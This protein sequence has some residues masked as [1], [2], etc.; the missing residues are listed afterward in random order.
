MIEKKTKTARARKIQAALAAI[1]I[2]AASAACAAAAFSGCAK[3]SRK[4]EPSCATRYPILLV[5][6]LSWRDDGIVSYWGTVPEALTERGARVYLSRHDA[7]GSI[8]DNAAKIDERVEAILAETGAGKVNVIAHSKGG[9]E[10]RYLISS[11]KRGDRVASLSTVGTPHRGTAIARFFLE[12]A[13]IVNETTGKAVDLVAQFI[14]GDSAPDARKAISQLTPEAMAAFN[15]RNRDDPRVL[16]QSW[17]S[18][19]HDD[20]GVGVYVLLYRA[21]RDMEGRNDGFVPV[22]SAK[23]GQFRG[24]IGEEDEL[25][26]SH[27]DVHGLVIYRAANRF[28]APAFYVRLVEELK[29]RGL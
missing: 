24:V 29:A 14:N 19:L 20:Y 28:D 25:P 11:L 12:D 15:A 13:P 27:S 17:T 21:L 3:D 5:H 7:W 6:G 10:T 8:E 2:G 1:A 18:E 9:I 16:Y 4:G 26:I 22:E 23:W